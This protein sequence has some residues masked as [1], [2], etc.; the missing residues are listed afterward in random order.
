MVADG[1]GPALARDQ[2]RERLASIGGGAGM[3]AEES[4]NANFAPRANENSMP[5]V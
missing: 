3:P 4:Q 1:R 5:L 2:E